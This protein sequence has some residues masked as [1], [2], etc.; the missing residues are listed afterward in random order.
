MD[1]TAVIELQNRRCHHTSPGLHDSL[2]RTNCLPT[3]THSLH[4]PSWRTIGTSL[5]G[6]G[7]FFTTAAPRKPLHKGWY[8]AL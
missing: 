3:C 8:F 1:T 7:C 4:A 6:W 5:Q 2:L